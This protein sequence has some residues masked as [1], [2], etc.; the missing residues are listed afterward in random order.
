[1][2]STGPGWRCPWCGRKDTPSR[3]LHGYAHDHVGYP[4]CVTD[5]HSCL[6]KFMQ[7]ITRNGVRAG[8]L[9]HMLNKDE[10]FSAVLQVQPSFY[11]ELCD[12]IHGMQS[13]PKNR[14]LMYRWNRLGSWRTFY[15]DD[16]VEETSQYMLNL[17]RNM[18]EDARHI[19]PRQQ[20]DFHFRSN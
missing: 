1:M 16:Q 5:A 14:V 6:E 11:L 18:Q 4:I 2:G 3:S 13:E 7:G 15:C 8:A 10:R 9:Y 19:P 12:F 17:M 20:A